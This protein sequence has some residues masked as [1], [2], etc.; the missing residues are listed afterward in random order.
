MSSDMA[1]TPVTAGM[2]DVGRASAFSATYELGQVIG[3]G[4]SSLVRQARHRKTGEI[5]AAKHVAVSASGMDRGRLRSEITILKNAR[6][7]N[8]VRLVECYE[9]GRELILVMEHARGG[10]LFDRIVA[11]GSYSEREA[12]EVA[13]KLLE[14]VAYLHDRGVV[15]RDLKPENILLASPES[16]TDVKVSDF[17]IAKVLLGTAVHAAESAG[18]HAAS[19]HAASAHA[20]SA[21]AAGRPRQGSLLSPALAF[22]GCGRQ[23]RAFSLGVGTDCY[24]APEVLSRGA[25][26]TESGYHAPVDLWSVGVVVYILL[27]GEPPYDLDLLTGALVPRRTSSASSLSAGFGPAAGARHGSASSA[28]GSSAG[29]SSAGGSS[30][31][32]VAGPTA[33]RTRVPSGHSSGLSLSFGAGG[34]FAAHARQGL[35]LGGAARGRRSTGGSGTGACAGSTPELRF[36]SPGW[37]SISDAAKDVVRGLLTF[38]P[39][40]RLTARQALEH[41]WIRGRERSNSSAAL[42]AGHMQQMRRYVLHR[43]ESSGAFESDMDMST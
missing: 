21:H 38:D 39:D 36:P 12:S 30:A 20:A 6:H 19:A 43:K 31:G 32:S 15:H 11:K 33:G 10:E 18:S 5:F 41:P 3:R 2:A 29:G 25:A 28:G 40:K 37:D 42:G 23:A 24:M 14:A 35:G 26:G 8:I 17:G 1:R 9:E 4:A 13:H 27:C 22:L 16:D 34:F 7:P